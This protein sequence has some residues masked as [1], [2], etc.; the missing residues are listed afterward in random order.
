[1]VRNALIS[2]VSAPLAVCAKADIL[3]KSP[4][5]FLPLQEHV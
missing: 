5:I 1:M 3:F 4:P 2:E